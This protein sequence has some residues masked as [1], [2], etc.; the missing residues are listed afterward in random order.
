MKKQLYKTGAI[1]MILGLQACSGDQAVSDE[2]Q[3]TKSN[4]KPAV[5]INP[6]VY[7][8]MIHS[9]PQPIELANIITQTKMPFS[10]EMLVPSENASSY[11]DKYT[12]AMALGAYGVDLG[13]INLNDKKLYVIEYLEALK[14]IAASLKVEQFFDFQTLYEMNN[15]RYNADS[16]IHLSTR[17]FNRI[18]EFLRDENRGELSVL[19]L[20][21]AWTEGIYMFGKLYIKSPNEDLLKRIGEQKVVFEN[22][23]LILEKMKENE[24]F[25]NMKDGTGELRKLYSEVKLEYL[26]HPP[27]TKEINGELVIVDKT[28][29]KVELDGA[30]AAS[31]ILAIDKFRQKYLLTNINTK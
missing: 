13:Y 6:A 4:T 10:K 11:P 9:L 29:T 18:D 28:E 25:K 27:E 3:I 22:I 2:S 12:Q 24:F 23:S 31:I 17:N 30:K 21:G 14:S 7:E 26:Y 20:I 8:E 1:I 16:L 5:Q 19:M 15:N